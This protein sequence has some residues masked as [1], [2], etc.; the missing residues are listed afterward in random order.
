MTMKPLFLA[1][2]F[3]M[4]LSACEQKPEMTVK[5][6][7]GATSEDVNNL[8]GMASSPIVKVTPV[9]PFVEARQVR[10]YVAETGTTA[11]IKPDAR[12]VTLSSAQRDTLA[13]AFSYIEREHP[14]NA[15]HFGSAAATPRYLFRYT[16]GAGKTI[17]E[18]HISFC[19]EA[20]TATPEIFTVPPATGARPFVNYQTLKDLIAQTK[21]ADVTACS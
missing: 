5:T 14:E 11:D 19:G 10:L 3:L 4:V 1:L 17:G 21:V 15:V 20:I 18:I 6:A 2:G 8:I 12:Y 13:S 9:T 16:D 7:T